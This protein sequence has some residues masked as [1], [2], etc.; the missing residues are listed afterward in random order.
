LELQESKFI[1]RNEMKE[2]TGKLTAMKE[3]T[4]EYWAR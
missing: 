4:C 2:V 1:G 3:N